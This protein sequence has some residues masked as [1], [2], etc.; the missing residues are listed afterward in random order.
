[1]V[2]L[3][4]RGLVESQ[5]SAVTKEEL[6]AHKGVAPLEY[7]LTETGLRRRRKRVKRRNPL[8]Q[9]FGRLFPRPI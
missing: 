3:G 5:T 9:L 1:M 7:R 8:E 2:E 6:T 4:K